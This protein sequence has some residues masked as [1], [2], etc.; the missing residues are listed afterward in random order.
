MLG[1]A[2][3]DAGTDTITGSTSVSGCGSTS[4]L[5]FSEESDS[6]VAVGTELSSSAAV[7]TVD[8]ELLLLQATIDISKQVN[9]SNRVDLSNAIVKI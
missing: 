5:L 2:D 1:V 3:E 6:F 9:H 8:E 7:T 4:R